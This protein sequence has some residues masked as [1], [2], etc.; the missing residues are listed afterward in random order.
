M[1]TTLFRGWFTRP[2][3]P[4]IVSAPAWVQTQAPKQ[5]FT[6]IELLVVIAIIAILAAMLLPALARAK[7]RA[8]TIKC[9][10]N[11]RQLGL[12]ANLYA[13][14]N[15][16][17][18]P[19]GGYAHGDFFGSSIAP[20]LGV[21]I[22]STATLDSATLTNMY[23]RNTVF[24]CPAWP[25]RNIQN[26]YGLQYAMNNVDV[27]RTTPAEATFI[28]LSNV[29]RVAEVAYL[30]E[31]YAGAQEL[32]WVHMDI[33]APKQATFNEY[34]AVNS[35]ADSLRMISAKDLRHGGRTTLSFMDGHAEIRPLRRDKLPW[36]LFQPLWVAP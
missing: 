3:A 13:S 16:D 4:S 22:N 21:S 18:L 35:I 26:D 36:T 34:G 17:L 33:H 10:S 1:H 12:A 5:A 19:S 28:R 9:V 11:L 31:L 24:R 23:A 7:S 14:D 6:L 30:V 25:K 2:N 29:P 32:D 15:N 20:Y 27:T 8:V